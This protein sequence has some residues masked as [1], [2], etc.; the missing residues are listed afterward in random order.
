MF[1]R[2]K[3]LRVIAKD[4][5]ERILAPFLCMKRK[6]ELSVASGWF[7]ISKS[8]ASRGCSIAKPGSANTKPVRG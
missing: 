2:L 6:P 4:M 8:V 3:K 7:L 5:I 1:V